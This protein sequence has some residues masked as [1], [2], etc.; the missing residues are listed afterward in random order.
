MQELKLSKGAV[1]V[2]WEGTEYVLY[3]PTLGRAIELESKIDGQKENKISD[4][5]DFIAEAGMPKEVV[6]QLDADNLM[7]IVEAMMPTKKK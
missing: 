3:K 2:I 1:K 5:V 6:L 4:L 7:A